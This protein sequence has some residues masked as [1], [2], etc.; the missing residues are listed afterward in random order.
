MR[1]L[2]CYHVAKLSTSIPPNR[3]CLRRCPKLSMPMMEPLRPSSKAKAIAPPSLAANRGCSRNPRP[4]LSLP[5]G[6][7]RGIQAIPISY[8]PQSG[9]FE[10]TPLKGGPE[11][12]CPLKGVHEGIFLLRL[13]SMCGTT[14]ELLSSHRGIVCPLAVAL[15][16]AL[17][18][19][20]VLEAGLSHKTSSAPPQRRNGRAFSSL[21]ARGGGLPFGVIERRSLIN[22]GKCARG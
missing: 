21:T 19:V 1:R 4:A 9:W 14:F 6:S 18:V 20:V 16:I 3:R 15:R 10:D 2:T 11:E 22:T 5:P 13:G 7:P 17:G 12:G 8:H